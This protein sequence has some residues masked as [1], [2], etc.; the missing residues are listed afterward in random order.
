MRQPKAFRV[1]TLSTPFLHVIIILVV[2][3]SSV[4]R[5]VVVEAQCTLC[6]NDAAPA[7]IDKIIPFLG[8]PDGNSNPTCGDLQKSA[9]SFPCDLTEGHQAFC[10]CPGTSSTP[11]NACSLCDGELEPGRPDSVTPFGDT[12]AELDEY[13]SFLSPRECGTNRVKL[14]D[15]ADYF[16]RCP[17]VRATFILFVFRNSN[18]ALQAN[19]LRRKKQV[20]LTPES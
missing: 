17:G 6:E 11:L 14:I 16:C 10:G 1:A 15:F 2:L 8:T 13:M 18:W 20:L 12:C 3:S 5:D 19:T 4:L 9:T 7:N